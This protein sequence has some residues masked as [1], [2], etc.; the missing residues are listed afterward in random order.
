MR[1]N[2]EI[3][4]KHA[5][6][7]EGGYVNHPA[8]PGGATNKGV[9]QR[10][11]DGYRRRKGLAPRSVRHIEYPEI[12]DIYLRQYW[13]A[14]GCDDLPSGVDV[15]HFDGCINSGPRQQA[16][17]LQRALRMN[18]IDGNIGEATKAAAEAHPNHD[19]LIDEI[20]RRRLA[21]L[22]S[23]TKLWPHFGKGWEARLR[24]VK[25]FGQMLATGAEAAAVERAQS[26]PIPKEEIGAA[27]ASPEDAPEPSNTLSDIGTGMAAGGTAT[28]TITGATEALAPI[29]DKSPT[30]SAVY[31]AL[32]IAG[33]ALVVGG[34]LVRLYAGRKQKRAA[35]SL[36]G[37]LIA[38]PGALG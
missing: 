37:S 25:A 34:I 4:L 33:V 28:T 30:L 13:I 26:A 2:F 3:G 6:K 12:R 38:A 8:D 23:L 29:A 11:Y 10:V 7:E 9:T 5:L 14:G 31:T 36:D 20:L 1:A 16:L 15:V 27:R 19:A 18:N 17:W 22:R 21:F 35:Q 24:R 32:V